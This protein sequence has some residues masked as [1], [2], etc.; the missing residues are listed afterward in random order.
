M[1]ILFSLIVMRMTGAVAL[2]PVFGRTNVPSRVKAAFIF[3]FSVM[4]YVSQ[5]GELVKEPDTFVEYG[6]M[7]LGELLLGFVIGFAIEL[8][9]LVV[10]YAS[11][12]MDFSMGLSMAQIYD[13]EHNTQMTVTNGLF[14]AFFMLLFL[15]MDGHVWLIGLFF[16]TAFIIP[17]GQVEFNPSL[18]EE[19]LGMFQQSVYMGIQ[20][21][22]PL[23]AMELVTEAAVGILMKIIPQIDV[24]VVNFQIK[25]MVGIFMLLYLFN[26]ISDH[27]YR[28]IDFLEESV[29]GLIRFFY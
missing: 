8:A 19:V 26:P 28:I 16:R 3:A 14:Y 1:F 25:L 12:V 22:F 10:Q 15:A 11:A 7:L 21:A 20:M 17:F 18:A 2:N 5:G 9:L 24:F 23:I 4:L 27:L 6:V 13:P 29:G